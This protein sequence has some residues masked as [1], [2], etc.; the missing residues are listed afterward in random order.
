LIPTI[1]LRIRRIIHKLARRRFLLL[2]IVFLTL[3]SSSALLFYHYEKKSGINIETSFYWA[4][5]TMA[6]VGYGDVVP[7]TSMGRL[8][9]SAAAVFGIAVYTLFI[10]TL[11]DY[12]M[13]ATVRAAMGL[14][15][16]RGKRI[17]V[18]GEGPVCEEAVRELVANGLKRDTGWILG[19]QPKSKPPVDYIVGGLE[20]DDLRRAGIE[21]A[22]YAIVCYEDDSRAIHA[23][24][25]VKGLNPEVKLTVLAK[26][27]ARIKILEQMGVENIVP[28]AVLGRLL[29]S[30]TFEPSVTAFLSDATT[31]RKGVDLSEYDAKNKTVSQVEE[32]TGY[33][34][35]ALVDREGKVHLPR[36]GT[37]IRE[38][39]KVIVLKKANEE[40]IE[41][42]KE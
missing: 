37:V 39:E 5:I 4:L 22:E 40:G 2:A 26:D 14:G 31:A 23:A 30:S 25:L 28:V 38:G 18:V 6:T 17:L 11:A 42:Q 36:P 8:V 9:A 21:E 24:A 13:E 1:Y 33:R 12:F 3:W 16:L 27:Q 41:R 20:E 32:E 19:N 7:T 29:A 34:V 35:V 10:S 15:V